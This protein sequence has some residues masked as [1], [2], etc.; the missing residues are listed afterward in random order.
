MLPWIFASLLLALQVLHAALGI[1]V[2]LQNM[3]KHEMRLHPGWHPHCRNSR[4]VSLAGCA[5]DSAHGN[6]AE[7]RVVALY[8]LN[9]IQGGMLLSGAADGSVRVW[10]NFSHRGAQ[11]LAS[12]WRVS[13]SST[14]CP[15]PDPILMCG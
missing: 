5:G 1:A 14:A 4:C 9:E 3:L 2:A 10:R 7:V 15:L 12:A 6:R 13:G 11:R 8:H